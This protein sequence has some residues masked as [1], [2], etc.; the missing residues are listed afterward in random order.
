MMAIYTPDV[1]C[2][3]VVG[4]PESALKAREDGVILR[5]VKRAEAEVTPEPR[6]L[7]MAHLKETPVEA[8]RLHHAYFGMT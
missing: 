2:G 8:K 1:G 3:A 4:E 5:C 6:R 7:R